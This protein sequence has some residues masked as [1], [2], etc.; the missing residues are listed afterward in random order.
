MRSLTQLCLLGLVAVLACPLVTA[1]AVYPSETLSF[2]G[3]AAQP[4][5]FRAPSLSGSTRG[6][7]LTKSN[8]ALRSTEWGGSGLEGSQSLGITFTWGDSVPADLFGDD[9][10]AWVRLTTLD[11]AERPNPSLHTQGK[12]RF[13]VMNPNLTSDREALG[14]CVAVRET[15]T[16][17]PQMWNGGGTGPIELVG[18]S[19]AL[20][21][22]ECGTNGCQSVRAGDD[23]Q[24]NAG[25]VEAIHWGADRVLQT[26]PLGDD[27]AKS[28]YIRATDN[29]G[30]IPIPA[31]TIPTDLYAW[32]QVEVDLSAGTISYGGGGGVGKVMNFNLGDGILNPPNN[33]G[34][35]EA[36]CITNDLTNSNGVIGLYIDELQFEA[37]AHDPIVPP[38]V[39][40]SMDPIVAGETTVT[41]RDLVP[42]VKKVYLFKNGIQVDWQPVTWTNP[43]EVKFVDFTIAPP[44]AVEGDYYQAK[45]EDDA[46]QLSDLCPPAYVL[47]APPPYSFGLL[48]NEQGMNSPCAY[49]M[50]EWVP[51]TAENPQ[52]VPQGM[53]LAP[54]DGV[55]QNVD[56]LLHAGATVLADTGGNAVLEPSPPAGNY[57]IDTLWFTP[58]TDIT[59][60]GPWEVFID[61]VQALDS[62]NN[63]LA[64]LMTFEDGLNRI[65]NTRGQSITP[66]TSSTV[67]T[68]ASYDGSRSHRLLWTYNKNPDGT[69]PLAQSL[70]M[71]QRK[72]YSC[73]YLVPIPD[74]AFKVR[75]HMLL[76]DQRTNTVALPGVVG[77]IIK[78]TN[79][80]CS[81]RVT[82]DATATSVQ[83]WVNGL[84]R[85]AAT[86]T[87]TDTDFTG[88]TLVVGDSVSAK[89][90]LPAGTSDL[91]YPRVVALK[92]PPPRLTPPIYP[93]AATATV[94]NLLD[95]QFA[96]AL[97]VQVYKNAVLPGNLLGS[98]TGTLGTSEIVNLSFGTVITGDVVLATQVV[99]GVKS[100]PSDPVSVAFPGPVIFKAPAD[101]ETTVKVL[102]LLPGT[103]LVTVHVDPDHVD[104]TLSGIS[105]GPASVEVPVNN[106]NAGD[107][108]TAQ[109]TV[110]NVLSALSAPDTVTT[111]VTTPMFCDGFEYANQAAFEAV[112][113]P[114]T[115]GAGTLTLTADQNTT[116]GGSKSL[117]SANTSNWQLLPAP[118]TP[119]PQAP[120]VLTASIYDTGGV[121]DAQFVDLWGR[122]FWDVTGDYFMIEVGMWYDLP[123]QLTRYGLRLLGGGPNWVSLDEYEAPLRSVGWHSFTVVHKGLFVDAYVDGKLAKKNIVL[124]STLS[125]QVVKVGA[126]PYGVGTMYT[127]DYC[128]TTGPVRLVDI[129]PPPPPGDMD[130]D[131]DV[132]L[133]D[134]AAWAA[135]LAGP[136]VSTPPGGCTAPQFAL[137]DLDSDLDVDD[138]DF[139]DFQVRFPFP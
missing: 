111:N 6:L 33:R 131:G 63:V 29:G 73:D 42:T 93:G 75:F 13:K 119:T 30:L 23:I 11:G 60:S 112:W 36:L 87:S 52:W 103:S 96:D 18:V 59:T 12:I 40:D 4:E 123:D 28:G 53:G 130:G 101:G 85:T 128:A 7:D 45:Q 122:Y 139:A 3:A 83:L 117:Y 34:T 136:N 14:L 98:K 124:G 115:Q 50:M 114:R 35:L 20:S 72:G 70:G 69:I 129:S 78:G 88:L 55:W 94:T 10:Y 71:L 62:S 43:G 66:V 90:V 16:Q 76:R 61:A 2:E 26:T 21:V 22:I 57:L 121:L 134:Y 133:T 97:W 82:N 5:V 46:A 56:V 137:A 19:T 44:G 27:V 113:T 126:A 54:K 107:T 32:T 84:Y 127:D 51:V 135:C 47:A 108:L 37:P 120:I 109:M 39:A 25:G 15:D 77:P 80:T 116:P 100:D 67:S 118:V 31:L 68:A 91:A 49:S 81:V 8:T 38:R 132:D 95:V 74:T 89:Q 125:V 102:G 138:G 48:I 99:N 24:V 105:G 17:V 86:P 106:L 110:D 104:F 65:L 41:V 58:T 1:G 79:P 9:P 64:T 92:A